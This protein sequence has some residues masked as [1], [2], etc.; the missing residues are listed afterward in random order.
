[1]QD[2]FTNPER[3]DWQCPHCNATCSALHKFCGCCGEA[4]P[5]IVKQQLACG[6][7]G[8]PNDFGGRY[9]VLCGKAPTLSNESKIESSPSNY[10]FFPVANHK[11]ITLSIFTLGLY[12]VYWFY[13]NWRRV[14][15]RT[16]TKISPFWRAIFSPFWATALFKVI[17][18]SAEDKTIPA[19]W[20]G[21]RPVST[22]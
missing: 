18:K 5:V 15:V 1:M 10:P 3:S 22:V 17:K 21:K 9:C 2:S 19:S 11:F 16:D 7:C 14:K 4:K 8:L 12:E 6:H 20:S 13:Q